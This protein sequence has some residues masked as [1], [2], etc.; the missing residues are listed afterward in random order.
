MMDKRHTTERYV[1]TE[2]DLFLVFKAY[3]IPSII[4][5]KGNE[6]MLLDAN[7]STFNT[8]DE[9]NEQIYIIIVTRKPLKPIRSFGIIKMNDIY[10]IPKS[11]INEELFTG[12]RNIN[13]FV[14]ILLFQEILLKQRKAKRWPD[15]FS[16][17]IC[18]I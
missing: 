6:K 3:N 16:F 13:K 17:A 14:S 1:P 12:V 2:V 9:D 15:V 18:I 5:M 4:K 10:R 7:V 8:F 11:I